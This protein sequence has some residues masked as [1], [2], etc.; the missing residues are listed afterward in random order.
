MDTLVFVSRSRW[1]EAPRL[2]HQLAEYLAPYFR[3]EFVELPGAWLRHGW[4][5][6]GRRRLRER[7]HVVTLGNVLLPPERVQALSAGL[8]RLLRRSL[9]R[10][11]ERAAPRR[12]DGRVILMN[13]THDHPGLMRSPAFDAS[14]YVCNDD[15]VAQARPGLREEAG[16]LERETAARADLCLAVSHPLQERLQ[17]FNARTELLLPGHPFGAEQPFWRAPEPPFV[18]CFM[19]YLDHRI[20]LGW[21]AALLEDPAWEVRLIGKRQPS[22]GD[23]RAL[24]RSGRC[25]FLGELRGAELFRALSSAHV[26]AMP[27]RLEGG[28]LAATA[29]NKLF[30]YLA[31]GRPVVSS[32]LPRLL[33]LPPHV[34]ARAATA[35]EFVSAARE[36]A[37]RD[38]EAFFRERVRLAGEQAW[39]GKALRLKERLDG[40]RRPPAA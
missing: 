6:P 35:A 14:V 29:P 39:E 10:R 34:L 30:A 32:A 18:L 4:M 31:T 1:E 27:Y 11:V 37:A 8:R 7:F 36:A 5:R 17:R 23:A 9:T 12:G 25:R 22:L 21:L 24:E 33:E 20:D 28:N 40:L 15:W 38:C 26:L 2:R 13:F 3:I 19:G 16:G